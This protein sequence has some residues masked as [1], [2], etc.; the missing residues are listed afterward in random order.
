MFTK[1][2]LNKYITL[3]GQQLRE[4]L[5]SMQGIIGK[6]LNWFE[7]QLWFVIC[8]VM[9][10]GLMIFGLL[11]MLFLVLVVML[12]YCCQLIRVVMRRGA[13]NR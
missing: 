6:G 10:L 8:A 3:K 11:I 13:I 1:I 12:L 2:W 5:D 7:R 9:G 4:K